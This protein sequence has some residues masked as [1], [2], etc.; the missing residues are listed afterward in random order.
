[1]QALLVQVNE[2]KA[3]RRA[4][5]EEESTAHQPVVAMLGVSTEAHLRWLC[6][7]DA[8]TSYKKIGTL[9]TERQRALTSVM[10]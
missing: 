5:K 1:M 2:N 10:E 4:H 6:E 8:D 3:G 7:K 9:L